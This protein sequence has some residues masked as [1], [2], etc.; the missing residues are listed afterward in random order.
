MRFVNPELSPDSSPSQDSG[1]AGCQAE[2][3]TRRHS[4]DSDGQPGSQHHCQL[5]AESGEGTFQLHYL[6]VTD[7]YRNHSNNNT[8]D[9]NSAKGSFKKVRSIFSF[10]PLHF[11]KFWTI[12]KKVS[13]TDIFGIFVVINGT[14][15][16]ISFKINMNSDLH[17]TLK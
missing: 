11:G 3:V 5:S 17:G 2:P 13:P 8:R 16:I 6:Q 10:N 15:G 1:V 7:L 12:W 9:I 14:E 4:Q